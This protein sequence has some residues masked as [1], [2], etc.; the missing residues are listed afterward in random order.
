MSFSSWYPDI[1]FRDSNLEE[2]Q[3]VWKQNDDDHVWTESVLSR[4]KN[5]IPV[6]L[7]K[8]GFQELQGGRMAQRQLGVL[9][10]DPHEDMVSFAILLI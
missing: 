9:R 4:E 10:E 2:A 3:R 1:D 8:I 7:E 6:L 5:D